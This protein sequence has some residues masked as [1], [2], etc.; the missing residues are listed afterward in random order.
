MGNKQGAVDTITSLEQDGLGIVISTKTQGT[1][2]QYT[3][4]KTD[5][6]KGGEAELV[7]KL[8]KYAVTLRQYR[9]SLMEE[10]ILPSRTSAKRKNGHESALEVTAESPRRSPRL[11]GSRTDATPRSEVSGSRPRNLEKE[12]T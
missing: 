1:A 11:T 8:A 12:F 10:E 3:F 7:D 6:E 4:V 5:I 9:Q 2:K